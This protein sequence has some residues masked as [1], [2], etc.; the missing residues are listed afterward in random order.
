MSGHD[1]NTAN[2][3]AFDA[4]GHV[5][6]GHTIVPI[7]TLRLVLG[8]LL[9]FTLLTVFLSRGEAWLA[10]FMHFEIPQWINVA[11]ALAIAAV[12]TAIVVLFFMQL[13]YDNPINGMIFI[14]TLIIVVFFLG[15]T[16]IDLGKRQT[17]DRFKGVYITPGGTG[18]Q[19]Q[20]PITQSAQDF[21]RLEGHTAHHPSIERVERGGFT[22][23]GYRTP[24]PILGSSEQLARPVR[25][26]TLPGL[27][28][29]IEHSNGGHGGDHSE[30]SPNGDK[31]H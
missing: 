11:V 22:D 27:A 29:A 20:G 12:K 19:G 9:F 1:H 31:P 15:F 16:M 5:G 23:A 30:G 6:H 26:L 24:V 2:G 17:I 8:S 18:L 13:K 3:V 28:P 14:F 10:N 25:G 21:A 4:H 7:V